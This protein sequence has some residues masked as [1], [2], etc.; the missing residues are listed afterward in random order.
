MI[1][2]AIAISGKMRIFKFPMTIAAKSIA[3]PLLP[4]PPYMCPN[5]GMNKDKIPARIG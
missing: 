3:A 4:F 5:P 1:G 2:F